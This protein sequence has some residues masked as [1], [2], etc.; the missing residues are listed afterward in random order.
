[1][2]ANYFLAK[3]KKHVRKILIFPSSYI[4][5]PQQLPLSH[6]TLRIYARPFTRREKRPKVKLKKTINQVLEQ[7]G[8]S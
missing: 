1:M 2:Y 4:K 8:D 7:V 6:D 5:P 3:E